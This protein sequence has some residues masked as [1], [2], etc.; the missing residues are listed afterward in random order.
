MNEAAIAPQP[1]AENTTKWDDLLFG[2]R[3]SIRYHVHRRKF[4]DSLGTWTDFLT[5]ISGGTVVAFASNSGTK[6]TVPIIIFAS[7]TAIFTAFD[8]VLG[9]SI[10]AREHFDLAKQFSRLEQEIVKIWDSPTE[11]DYREMLNKRIEIESE[12]P[13]PK[14]I[15]D[16][17]C[18]NELMRAMG[19]PESAMVPLTF[20]QYH[21]KQFVSL[22]EQKRGK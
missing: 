7:I 8:L 9:F 20:W 17:A 3:R 18:H 13:P 5:I 22:G 16:T 6:E 4:F 12:E 14:R 15:L 1:T 2:V 19:Y 21:L 10:K 11:S